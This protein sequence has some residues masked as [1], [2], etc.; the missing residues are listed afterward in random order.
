[1]LAQALDVDVTAVA[2]PFGAART[3]ER[4]LAAE[5]GYSAGFD[6]AAR[7]TGDPMA[8]PRLPVYM[9]TPPT[10]CVGSLGAIERVAAMA[11]NHFAVG[12]TIWQR[13]TGTFA[14]LEG[15]THVAPA[16]SVIPSAS[17][18]PAAPIIPA[19]P[20]M[21]AKAGSHVAVPQSGD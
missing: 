6:L 12:T 20:A 5:A 11:T 17:V 18:I 2:Y 16:P 3:R 21:P 10:P 15:S 13:L 1:A 14:A 19:A 4:V 8:I 7:F 9:W